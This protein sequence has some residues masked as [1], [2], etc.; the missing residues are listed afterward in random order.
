MV[1]A[2]VFKMMKTMAHFPTE[3]IFLVLVKRGFTF[4]KLE[5]EMTFPFGT[6]SLKHCIIK[7]HLKCK[8]PS[9]TYYC[10]TSVWWKDV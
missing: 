2:L 1:Y 7:C 3:Y 8:F 9:A 10:T 5:E 6:A 4:M